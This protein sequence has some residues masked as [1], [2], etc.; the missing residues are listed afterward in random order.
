MHTDEFGPWCR[1]YT[2]LKLDLNYDKLY[3]EETCEL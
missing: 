1:H 3:P 2:Y